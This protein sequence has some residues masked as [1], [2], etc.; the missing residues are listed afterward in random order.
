MNYITLNNGILIPQLGIGGFAQDTDAIVQAIRLGYR[1]IDTAAQY[2]NEEQI[3][4]A[5]QKCDVA[6]EEMF[7]S[8]KLWT[9]D[10]RKRR[11]QDAFFESLE[12][13]QV[14]YVDL[15]LIHWPTEGYP[16]AWLEMEKLYREGY[17]RAIGV[18][19]FH[20]I[21][22][23]QIEQVATVKPAVNQIESHPGF[24]N[25]ELVDHCRKQNIHIEAWC[26]LGG[27]YGHILEDKT[28]I[29]IADRYGKTPAQIVL[30]WHMQ[31]GIITFPKSS[32]VERMKTNL[33]IFDFVL[34]EDDMERIM[35][36][37][38][39][40]RIGADPENFDF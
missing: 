5:I 36:L 4:L 29:E 37:D 19:N 3:G 18:S 25:Q 33:D 2:G 40:C 21:H 39:G 12:R 10:I 28:I 7:L 17:V 34:S 16:E 13:L 27:A 24:H 15:Y 38:T 11:T 23:Q 14:D 22:L 20:H 32:H 30:R 8:T 9:D 6:R 1:L 35:F 26:P 31:R